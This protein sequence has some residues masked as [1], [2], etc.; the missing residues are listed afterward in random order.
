MTETISQARLDELVAARVANFRPQVLRVARRRQSYGVAA[1]VGTIVA[2]Q[3]SWMPG[4]YREPAMWLTEGVCVVLAIAAVSNLTK[5]RMGRRWDVTGFCRDS[6][7]GERD[8]DGR[9]RYQV[10]AG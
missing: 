5:A 3:V 8:G 9:P 10:D 7:L 6:V 1:L 4:V 2:G